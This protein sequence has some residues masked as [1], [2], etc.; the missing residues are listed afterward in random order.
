MTG[1][2]LFLAYHDKKSVKSSLRFTNHY[3]LPGVYTGN[4]T[5]RHIASAVN[6]TAFSLV[7]HCQDCLH[8]SQNGTT[9]S[10][11]TSG[12]LMDF[13]YAQS[14]NP[15]INRS[16]PDKAIVR[17]HDS[18]GTWSALLDDS[19]A[20]SS[21]HAWRAMGNHTIPRHCPSDKT[22]RNSTRLA[23]LKHR[24]RIQGLG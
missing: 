10:A 12:T 21:Y 17:E 13:G 8:W 15:P 14:I 4:A 2:P 23:M 11:S 9:G 7:F 22:G 5:V 24:N 1:S 19:I 6:S 3:S 20:S 16:C 18:H